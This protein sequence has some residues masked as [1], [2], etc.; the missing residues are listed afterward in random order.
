MVA[1]LWHNEQ[2]R[3]PLLFSSGLHLFIVLLLLFPAD[4]FQRQRL[5]EIYTVDLVDLSQ[6][7]EEPEPEPESRPE[8]APTPK[9]QVKPKEEAVSTAPILSSRAMPKPPTEIKIIRPRAEK[10]IMRHKRDSTAVLAAFARIKEQEKLQQELAEAEAKAE[11]EEKRAMENMAQAIMARATPE[12]SSPTPS[13]ASNSQSSGRGIGVHT[14]DVLRFYTVR[15]YNTIKPYWELPEGQ[16]WPED[17]LAVLIV[18][19]REDGQLLSHRFER[20]SGNSQFDKLVVR[21]LEK[22]GNLPPLPPE[23]A[24]NN[25]SLRLNFMPKFHKEE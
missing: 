23:L 7:L 1:D 11:Q 12:T 21:T 3:K 24:A 10:K 19:I 6:P 17:L 25:Y 15:V 16:Q 18:K 13:K 8:P 14:E 4:L 9:P 2:T 20:H 22:A 5:P